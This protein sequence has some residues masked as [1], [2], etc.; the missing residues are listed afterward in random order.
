MVF[1]FAQSLKYK[2]YYWVSDKKESLEMLDYVFM[3]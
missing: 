1:L 3:K 2:K